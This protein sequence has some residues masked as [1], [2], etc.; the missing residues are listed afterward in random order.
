MAG[1]VVVGVAYAIVGHLI[2]DLAIDIADCLLGPI[3]DED[4]KDKDPKGMTSS[5]P[6]SGHPFAHNAFHVWDQDDVVIHFPAE[7]ESPQ[8]S[9][10]L[11]AA[12]PYMPSFFPHSQSPTGHGSMSFAASP[13]SAK[14]MNTPREI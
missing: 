1:M 12:I 10:I 11:L 2:K 7:E 8:L 14:D 9:P 4:N 5:Y 13:G 3:G 6:P